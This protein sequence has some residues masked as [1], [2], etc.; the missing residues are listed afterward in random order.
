MTCE[1]LAASGTLDQISAL[2][3]EIDSLSL[4]AQEANEMLSR[5]VNAADVSL[6]AGLPRI[7]PEGLWTLFASIVGLTGLH[8]AGCVLELL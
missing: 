6:D 3:A 1:V 5:S 8:V 4:A 2:R 7:L